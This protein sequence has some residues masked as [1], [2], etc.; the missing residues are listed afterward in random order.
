MMSDVPRLTRRALAMTASIGM[1]HSRVTTIAHTMTASVAIGDLSTTSSGVPFT[2]TT[3]S[4]S[5]EISVNTIVGAYQ[6]TGAYV[7]L[8]EPAY[9]TYIY[10]AIGIVGM[11]GNSLVISVIFNFTQMRKKPTNAFIINQSVTDLVV[12]VLLFVT[13]VYKHDMAGLSGL[14]GELFCRLWLTKLP[15]WSSLFASTYNLAAVSVERFIEVVFPITHKLYFSM[16]MAWWVIGV[17]WGFSVAFQAAWIIPTTGLRGDFCLLLG[18]WPNMQ[19]QQAV[20]IFNIV[21]QFFVPIAVLAI[22]YIGM[23]VALLPK[24]HPMNVAYN[25]DGSRIIT[26]MQSNKARARRNII[27]TLAIVSLCFVLCWVCNQMFFLLYALGYPSD[28][29]SEFYHFSIVAMFLNCCINPFIYVAKYRDFQAGL[30]LLCSKLKLVNLPQ[31]V[32]VTNSTT[33]IPSH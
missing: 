30:K 14:S 22:S 2:N 16:R 23:A 11:L 33:V 4:T 7:S 10:I 26:S 3:V 15:L 13:T 27:K 8:L 9:L 19:T 28:F 20:G 25:E 32:S 18:L 17:V 29:T 6:E 12:A 21:I 1:E 24:V 31:D 5:E